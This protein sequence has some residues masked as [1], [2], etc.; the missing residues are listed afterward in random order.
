MFISVIVE[1]AI[2][3]LAPPGAIVCLLVTFLTGV[4]MA[5]TQNNLNITVVKKLAGGLPNTYYQAN[6][7]PLMPNPLAR[8]PV[9]AVEPQGWLCHQLQ[10]MRDDFSGHLPEVSTWC[11][12]EGNAWIGP[13]VNLCQGFGESGRCRTFPCGEECKS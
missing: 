6:R 10:L 8:L 1:G 13:R 11:K 3:R 4:P 12:F 7:P 5:Q 2:M 9:S